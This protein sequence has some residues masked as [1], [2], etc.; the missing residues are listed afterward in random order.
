VTKPLP[1]RDPALVVDDAL[2]AD[3]TPEAVA[4]LL[5]QAEATGQPEFRRLAL[6]WELAAHP[7]TPRAVL[8]EL[9]DH[10]NP[11]IR[12][13][14][15]S[16]PSTPPP[17]LQQLARDRDARVRWGVAVNPQATAELLERLAEDQ[18]PDVSQAARRTLAHVSAPPRRRGRRV[19]AGR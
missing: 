17:V 5:E 9:A 13:A 12:G 7:A 15:A 18:D 1:P 6:R 8:V 11:G 10:E 16:N 3:P 2:A 4:R 14:A 19:A